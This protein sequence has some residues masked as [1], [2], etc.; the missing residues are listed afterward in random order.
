MNKYITKENI[1][2]IAYKQILK[3]HA[4]AYQKYNELKYE[5]DDN[6]RGIAFYNCNS[7]KRATSRIQKAFQLSYELT[8]LKEMKFALNI[9]EEFIEEP[10]IIQTSLASVTTI[11]N[12]SKIKAP[13]NDPRINSKEDMTTPQYRVVEQLQTYLNSACKIEPIFIENSFQ[14][15]LAL[16]KRDFNPTM[17]DK[18]INNYVNTTCDKLVEKYNLSIEFPC[19]YLGKLTK[20]NIKIK[21]IFC[22]YILYEVNYKSTKVMHY[23]TDE[24]QNILEEVLYL[25]HPNNKMFVKIFT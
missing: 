5:E 25:L 3:N 9:I 20:H 14:L 18:E 8:A 15:S 1:Y 10:V 16:L 24:F 23:E 7:L 13:Y 22:G 19:Y 4:K 12:A 11:A 21:T 2:N 6:K 17:S